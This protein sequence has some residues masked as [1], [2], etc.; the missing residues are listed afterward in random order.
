MQPEVTDSLQ[1]MDNIFG[2][3]Y[4]HHEIEHIFC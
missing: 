4:D 1:L 3:K 2:I